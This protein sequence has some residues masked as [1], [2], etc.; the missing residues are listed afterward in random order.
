MEAVLRILKGPSGEAGTDGGSAPADSMV[1]ADVDADAQTTGGDPDPADG[2][3]EAT[4]PVVPA[5]EAH[6]AAGE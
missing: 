6:G 3:T 5:E 4:D 2:E 1:D